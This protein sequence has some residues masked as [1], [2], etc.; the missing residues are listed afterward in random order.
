MVLC[1][2]VRLK[3]IENVENDVELVM[4]QENRYF[5]YYLR[6]WMYDLLVYIYQGRFQTFPQMLSLLGTLSFKY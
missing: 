4:P 1:L 6:F 2:Y 5:F 3:D